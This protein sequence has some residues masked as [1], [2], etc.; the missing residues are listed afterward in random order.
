MPAY[1]LAVATKM[2]FANGAGWSHFEDRPGVVET[3]DSV[4]SYGMP[5]MMQVIEDVGARLAAIH[6]QAD[7]LVVGDISALGGGPLEG[8]VTHDRGVDADLGL[9]RQG[10]F[11]PNGGFV[12]LAPAEL[13]LALSW[14]LIRLLL[15]TGKVEYI[16]LDQEHIDALK[17]YLVVERRMDTD[18][19][20]TVFPS[21]AASW[22]LK[23]VVRHAP[24]HASHLHIHVAGD[25]TT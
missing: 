4:R 21:Q 14:D 24:R 18:L 5:Q 1:L 10:G 6:P 3:F 2:A 11:Q 7:A 16:L 12:D 25:P 19:V 8:H 20:D 15:D 17:R 23:G 22:N 13:D 9:F